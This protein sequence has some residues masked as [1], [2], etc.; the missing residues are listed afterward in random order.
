MPL[1][2]TMSTMKI[3]SRFSTLASIAL[4]AISVLAGVVAPREAQAIEANITE[5]AVRAEYDRV[6]AMA[7]NRLEYKVRHI[8][9]PEREQADVALAR[10]RAGEDFAIVAQD[11]SR[12]PS[13]N[14]KGG[15]LGWSLPEYF[16][17][18]FSAVMVGLAP[19]RASV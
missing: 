11:L 4:L 6:A 16:V 8:L 19:P 3:T 7:A 10:I 12:D 1:P 14:R 5:E 17:D 9:V 15:D 2:L 18:Q 13:S